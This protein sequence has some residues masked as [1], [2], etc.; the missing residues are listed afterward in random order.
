MKVKATLKAGEHLL[1]VGKTGS[2]KSLYA[3]EVVKTF[4]REKPDIGIVIINPKPVPTFWD[5]LIKPTKNPPKWKAGKYINWKVSPW[6]DDDLN[7]FLWSIYTT[8][9]PC[10]LVFDEG[11][12]IKSHLFP[13]ATAL[14][15]QGREMKISV[16]TCTQRPID[17][18]RYSI[19]QAR[20]IQVFNIIG[21]DDLKALDSYMEIPLR[22]YI[23]PSRVVKGQVENGKKLDE[24][25]SLYY[26]V[27]TGD[28][29]LIPPVKITKDERFK[30]SKPNINPLIGVGVLGAIGLLI[31][32]VL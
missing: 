11:Q 1:I 22:A 9:K 24:F 14:W 16:I 27:K 29:E 3:K 7:D 10:L 21:E 13:S 4:Q 30:P 18:S 19:S 20:Y 15:R 25:N 2:G 12:N 17:I 26:D 31:K 5:D 23:C 32:V 8:G 28:V 6:E